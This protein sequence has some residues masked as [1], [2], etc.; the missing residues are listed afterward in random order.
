MFSQ[1]SVCLQGVFARGWGGGVQTPPL[2]RH[3]PWPDTPSPWQTPLSPQQT[4]P[5]DGQ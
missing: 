2:G 1:V 5:A 4:P 3:L